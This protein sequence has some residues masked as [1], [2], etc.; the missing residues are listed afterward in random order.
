[1]STVSEGFYFEDLTVGM[2]ASIERT[3]TTDDIEMFA[4]AVGDFN[5]I[6]MNEEWARQTRF[7]GRIAHGMLTAGIVSSVLGTRLPGPGNVYIKQTLEFRAPVTPRS[8]VKA[9][10]CITRLEPERNR[11]YLDTTCTCCGT[12]V[13]SGEAVLFVQSRQRRL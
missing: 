3:I 8:A 13:L 11:V 12:I 2:S 9:Q 10:V 6:H 1:M 7:G 5:P 4:T